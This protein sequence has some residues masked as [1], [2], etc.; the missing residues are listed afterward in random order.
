MTWLSIGDA[1]QQGIAVTLLK[2]PKSSPLPKQPQP[3][4]AEMTLS[5]KFSPD[6]V[7]MVLGTMVIAEQRCG[8]KPGGFPLNLAVAKL[9]QDLVDFM[10]DNRYAPLVQVKMMKA[11]EFISG[12]GK[13]R[14]C[15]A[16]R[17]VLL[18]FIPNVYGQ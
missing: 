7:A 4:K 3:P 18:K 17:E 2:T 11:D 12:M 6:D 13:P 5:K 1:K 16:M 9:G 10:P 8:Q 14:A 15:K